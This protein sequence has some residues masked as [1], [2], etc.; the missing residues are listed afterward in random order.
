MIYSRN[1]RGLSCMRVV[2]I[3]ILTYYNIVIESLK[4]INHLQDSFTVKLKK[5]AV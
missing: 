3:H 5:H 4:K 2:H 1:K